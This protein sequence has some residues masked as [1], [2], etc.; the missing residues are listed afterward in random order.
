VA[1]AAAVFPVFGPDDL[2]LSFL[3]LCH[4]FER[5]AGH[6]LMLSRGVTVAYA[7]SVEAVPAN[8]TEVR[9][10]VVFSVPRL[11]EK[12]HARI[13]EKVAGDPPVRQRIF[14]WGLRVGQESFRHRVAKT[15]PPA[16]LR[17]RR[18]LAERLVFAKI[19]KRVGG[20][21][22]VF[23]S[24]GAPLSRELAEF[25]G[26][27]GLL[28]LEGYG[29]TETS[30]VITV[31]RPEDFRP[32]TVGPPVDGRGGQ[33]RARRRDP[34]PR[35]ARHEGLLQE[36]RGHRGGHR[37]ARLVPHRRRRLAWRTASSP[38]PTARRT[39]S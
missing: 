35:P 37:Q 3:P 15:R 10:T 21:L 36:A 16:A 11:Y 29:L 22:R 39:S 38:S 12:M 17:L 5:M 30:P 20:R 19:K 9:P 28:I 13:Q 1:A 18:A 34:D 6:Y 24:G 25:F 27:V 4:I 14:R 2:A 33:D 26:A 8:M 7:E 32:G 23:V 31:N